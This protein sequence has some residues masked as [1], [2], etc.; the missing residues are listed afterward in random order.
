MYAIFK[1]EA[2]KKGI[3]LTMNINLETEESYL[4]T[5]REKLDTILIQLLKNSIKYT[6]KGSI[7]LGYL[8]KGNYIEYFVKDSGIGIEKDKQQ[9]I[10]GRFTQADNSLSK[11]YD[12][13]GLG[14]SITKAYV[15]MLGGTIWVES[16][17]GKG[18][19]FYFTIPV[20][21][22]S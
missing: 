20:E 22:G 8:F 1:P 11:I 16:E 5:D 4:R 9:A 2:D 7:E 21:S 6:K 12:G 13:A 3:H 17:P 19:T 10:F 18:A 14:L 15:E